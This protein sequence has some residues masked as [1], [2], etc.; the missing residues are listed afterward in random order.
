[1]GKPMSLSNPQCSLPLSVRPVA[2]VIAWAMIFAHAFRV[3][4]ANP[5]HALR[6]E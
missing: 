6:Y 2:M 5:I 1:M 3:A 4:R